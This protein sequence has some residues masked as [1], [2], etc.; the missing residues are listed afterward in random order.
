MCIIRMLFSPDTDYFTDYAHEG[1][2]FPTWHRLFL[3]WL[4]RE[5]Q[6]QIND[7]TFRLPY[8]DWSDPSQREFLFTTDRLGENKNGQ[9]VGDLFN[10]WMTYCWEDTN[11]KMYPIPICDPTVSCNETLRRCPSDTLCGMDNPNWPSEADVEHAISIKTYD[12]DPYNR[13]VRGDDTSFRNFLEGFIVKPSCEGDTL[14]SPA[15]E[16]KHTPAITRKLHNTV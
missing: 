15:D 13:Y 6:I 11:G 14:C 2:G 8:W 5:I 16:K 1:T 9:V 3:L 7:H 4:E 12:T 10:N